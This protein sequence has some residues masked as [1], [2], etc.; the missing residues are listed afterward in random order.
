MTR[1]PHKLLDRFDLGLALASELAFN[2]DLL[3][4]QVSDRAAAADFDAHEKVIRQILLT[5]D[6]AT[7]APVITAQKSRF[8][9]RPVAALTLPQR[10]VYRAVVQLLDQ[11]LVPARGATDYEDF[12]EAPVG[13]GGRFVVITDLAHYY[14]TLPTPA[15]QQ[16]IMARS[17]E[18]QSVQWLGEFLTGLSPNGGGLPQGNNA[19]DRLGDTYADALARRLRRRGIECWRYADDFRLVAATYSDAI[20][21]LEAFSEEARKLGLLVNDSKTWITS[22]SQYR[23]RLES[24]RKAFTQA[25][26][27]KR[28][29]LTF[30]DLYSWMEIQPEDAEVMKGVALDELESWAK[31]A[32][33]LKTNRSERQE[34]RLDL[35]RV[36]SVLTAAKAVEALTHVPKLL[37]VE[38]Q[39]ASRIARY[40]DSL[41]DDHQEAVLETL[42]SAVSDSALTEWQATWLVDLLSRDLGG[43]PS[44]TTLKAW[45]TEKFRGGREVLR[46]FAGWS[47]AAQG[48]MSGGQWREWSSEA[49]YPFGQ[50]FVQAALGAI[51]LDDADG[52]SSRALGE[53]LMIEWGKQH[54]VFPF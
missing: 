31:V 30:V 15:L 29:E 52:K 28:G 42:S 46:A 20:E 7:E 48:V 12:Q 53:D 37:V 24:P 27:A 16:E 26:Q 6:V 54:F 25:W 34:E 18:W 2:S 1:V 49:L 13:S 35:A 38:P 3:P 51:E 32:D 39:L 41:I 22:M 45:T 43:G 5:E 50:C 21:S 10:V 33:S 36:M 11:W 8:G 17:G 9:R 47:S 14:V 19:S 4:K 23:S 40:L 44:A